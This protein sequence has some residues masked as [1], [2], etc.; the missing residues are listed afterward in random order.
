[1]KKNPYVFTIGFKKT[2][3]AHV[4]VANIL[5]ESRD[6]NDL[7][8]AAILQYMNIS[9]NNGSSVPGVEDLRPLIR[10]L[11]HQELRKDMK[12]EVEADEVKTHEPIA[13]LTVEDELLEIDE[14]MVQNVT[15]AISAFRKL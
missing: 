12:A 11:I 3:P 8:A 15:D 5:N 9:D 4:Q 7:I 6:K 13:R 1:M 14:D 2:N 10:E